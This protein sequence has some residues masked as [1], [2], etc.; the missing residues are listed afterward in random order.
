MDYHSTYVPWSESIGTLTHQTVCDYRNKLNRPLLYLCFCGTKSSVK[1]Y[2]HYMQFASSANNFVNMQC[3]NSPIFQNVCSI[4]ITKRQ[5][6]RFVPGR[7]VPSCQL[8]V[9]WTGQQEPPVE[10]AHRVK[11][12]GAKKPFNFFLIRPPSLPLPPPLPPLQGM[13]D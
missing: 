9:K 10:L 13:H 11:L 4:Q 1:G 6:D 2:R 8:Y 12:L 7:R 3:F 5:V